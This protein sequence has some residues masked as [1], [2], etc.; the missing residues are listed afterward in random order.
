MTDEFAGAGD[1]DLAQ[2]TGWINVPSGRQRAEY[3]TSVGPEVL[4]ILGEVPEQVDVFGETLL[5]DPY[6]WRDFQPGPRASAGGSPLMAGVRV[7]TA[8]PDVFPPILRPECIAVVNG[9][10]VWVTHGIIDHLSWYNR[11]EFNYQVNAGRHHG[12]KW[13]PHV[14]VDVL[15]QLR[16]RQHRAYCIRA[17][18]V[19]ID[20]TC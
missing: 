9:D 1:Y 2:L 14:N 8:A 16:D 18:G 12:P 13:G 20:E 19:T 4:R 5:I 6:L 10:L 17:S 3:V 7:K 15:V 11:S